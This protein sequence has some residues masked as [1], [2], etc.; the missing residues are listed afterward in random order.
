MIDWKHI[1]V[2]PQ[3]QLSRIV[4]HYRITGAHE[5]NS[6]LFANYSSFFQG[7]IFNLLPLTDIILEK[8]EKEDLSY[9]VYFVGQA[10]SPSV[11]YSTS[12]K[13][14]ILAVNFTLTGVYELTG[15][16]LQEYTDKIIDAEII[17]GASIRDLYEKILNCKED[18]AKI[19]CVEDYLQSYLKKNKKQV[20]PFVS[21]ALLLI[22][23]HRGNLKIKDLIYEINTSS[24]SLERAFQMEVGMTT[25]LYQRL[26]RF[27]LAKQHLLTSNPIDWWEIIIK[28]GFYDHSHLINEFKFFTGKTPVQF[29]AVSNYVE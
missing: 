23:E 3:P 15:C 10:I 12:R 20:K 8:E 13:Y 29:L 24:K 21:N 6:V 28:Y 25:K 2:L 9:P 4:K 17:F 27:N 5:F 1:E 19:A 18:Y 16:S 22:R 14:S 26:F 11:L 7:L